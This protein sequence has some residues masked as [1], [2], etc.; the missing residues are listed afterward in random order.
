MTQSG[1]GTRDTQAG[2]MTDRS[3]RIRD[4]LAFSRGLEP[5]RGE[6]RRVAFT[7]LYVDEELLTRIE[8]LR[9]LAAPRTSLPPR[10]ARYRLLRWRPVQ[11]A[12]LRLWNYFNRPERTRSQATVECIDL[13]YSELKRITQY[14]DR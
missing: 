11:R 8:L 2:T 7:P 13:I 12:I 9:R 14:V 3:Q 4:S 5:S 1:D 10:I 6:P